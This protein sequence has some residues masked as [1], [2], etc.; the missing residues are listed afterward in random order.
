VILPDDA[1]I[2]GVL[3]GGKDSCS[4]DDLAAGYEIGGKEISDSD[5]SPYPVR[6][7]TYA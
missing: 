4:E 3:D 7:G 6:A 2:V 1:N 5:R